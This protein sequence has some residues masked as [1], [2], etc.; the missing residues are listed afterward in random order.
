MIGK[1][2]DHKKPNLLPL[3]AQVKILYKRKDFYSGKKTDKVYVDY[4]NLDY[5]LV[6]KKALN[7]TT[8]NLMYGAAKYSREN[9][10][11]VKPPKLRYSKAFLRHFVLWFFWREKWDQESGFHHL[12]CCICSLL[13]LLELDLEKCIKGR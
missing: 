7:E 3:L 6:P 5:S 9:W 10:R 2:Y 13:F 12:A 8:K 1:K 4:S 11:K